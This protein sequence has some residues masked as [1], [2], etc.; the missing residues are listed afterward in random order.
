MPLGVRLVSGCENE[1]QT[2]RKSQDFAKQVAPWKQQLL[3][4]A[5]L[6]T[7]SSSI[8]NILVTAQDRPWR[9]EPLITV[10]EERNC[11]EMKAH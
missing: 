1:D 6:E 3:P 4:S 10:E 5:E 8:D 2:A 11:P 9:K 7:S